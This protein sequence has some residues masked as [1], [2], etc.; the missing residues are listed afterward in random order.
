[1]NVNLDALSDVT[2]I[3]ISQ[4]GYST[5]EFMLERQLLMNEKAY[6]GTVSK[7]DIDLGN[8]HMLSTNPLNYRI[9][10]IRRRHVGEILYAQPQP[11]GGPVVNPFL[12]ITHPAVVPQNSQ[13]FTINPLTQG[14]VNTPGEYTRLL[15][16]FFHTFDT[17]HRQTYQEVDPT[18]PQGPVIEIDAVRADQ[19]SNQNNTLGVTNAEPLGTYLFRMSLDQGGKLHINGSARF[20]CNF[21]IEISE[22]GKE[23]LGFDKSI[24]AVQSTNGVVNNIESNLTAADGLTIV[25]SNINHPVELVS[26]Q[27]IFR[28]MDHRL[29]VLASIQGLNVPNYIIVQNNAETIGNYVVDEVYP[30]QCIL[31]TDFETLSWDFGEDATITNLIT[32]P[33]TWFRLDHVLDLRYF[34]IELFMRRREFN[35][36][37]HKWEVQTER[38]DL[39]ASDYWNMQLTFVSI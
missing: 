5:S 29:S 10:E 30:S 28:A 25:V 36:T 9:F 2:K 3:N 24:L 22:Y 37:T 8:T 31:E 11:P 19:H 6:C 1:M 17:L 26:Q 16:R 12:S 18:F 38:L 7:F 4:I 20:W 32:K 13:T 21:F 27:S 34:R 15:N 35:P 39:Q 14:V 23:L 33:K